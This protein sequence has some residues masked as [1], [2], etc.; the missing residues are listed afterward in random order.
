MI[1]MSYHSYCKKQQVWPASATISASS[2]SKPHMFACLTQEHLLLVQSL[3]EAQS[4]TGI[5]PRKLGLKVVGQWAFLGITGVL[6]PGI[7]CTGLSMTLRVTCDLTISM[8]CHDEVDICLGA[9]FDF[10]ICFCTVWR[11]F[12]EHHCF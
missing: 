7:S 12:A 5:Y 3:Y 10:G 11:F 2:H 4:G 1:I 6:I 8:C 9:A